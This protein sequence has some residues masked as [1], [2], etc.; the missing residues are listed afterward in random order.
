[1]KLPW[2]PRIALEMMEVNRDA[3]K[4]EAEIVRSSAVDCARLQS[5]MALKQDARIGQLEREMIRSEARY[6]DLMVSYRMLRLQGYSDPAAVQPVPVEAADPIADAVTLA[7]KGMPPAM[8]AAMLAAARQDAKTM[9][10]E[11]VVQRV[12]QGHR[13]MDEF[14]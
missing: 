7:S 14:T 3:W 9:P 2:V 1:M 10:V 13:P 8:R 5:D 4:R 11:I 12:T 6:A